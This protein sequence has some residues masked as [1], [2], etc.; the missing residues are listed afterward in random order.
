MFSAAKYFIIL[1]FLALCGCTIYK[2]SDRKKF[3]TDTATVNVNH[4]SLINC[5]SHSIQ[6]EAQASKLVS[7]INSSHDGDSVYLWEHVINDA[8]FLETDNLKGVYCLYE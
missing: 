4:L 7:I 1:F 8:S 6:N 3:E 2:S 5:A